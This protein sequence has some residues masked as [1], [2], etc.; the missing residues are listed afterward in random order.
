MCVVSRMYVV[1]R[2]FVPVLDLALWLCVTLA[3]CLCAPWH[4]DPCYVLGALCFVAP[5]PVLRGSVLCGSVL[6]FSMLR[7]SMAP[8]SVAPWL[9]GSNLHRDGGSSLAES[10]TSCPN[11]S[12]ASR[13]RVE[14]LGIS[15]AELSPGGVASLAPKRQVELLGIS[16]AKLSPGCLGK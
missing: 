6:R 13:R 14:L 2:T 7:G 9:L 8:C 10:R 16:Q 5:S 4:R 12:R 15:Q 1:S 3:P 11:S